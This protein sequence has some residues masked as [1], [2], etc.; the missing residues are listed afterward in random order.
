MSLNSTVG[1]ERYIAV[2]SIAR[3]CRLLH[4]V[5]TLFASTSVE[6][7]SD[8]SRVRVKCIAFLLT[9]WSSAHVYCSM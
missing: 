4:P 3:C 8:A 2:G 1:I 5:K 7:I 6:T 9:T